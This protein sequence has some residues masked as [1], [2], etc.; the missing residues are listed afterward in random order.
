MKSQIHKR[1]ALF[2]MLISLVFVVTNVTAKKPV[3]P[4]PAD[5]P[6]LP[7][8]VAIM[9]GEENPVSRLYQP[10]V[11]GGGCLGES[12]MQ[13]G[14]YDV[15]FDQQPCATLTTDLDHSIGHIDGRGYIVLKIHRQNH[16]RIFDSAWIKGMANVDGEMLVHVSAEMI[17]PDTPPFVEDLGDGSFIVHLHADNVMLWQCN[18]QQFKRKTKCDTPAGTFAIEHLLYFPDN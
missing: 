18:S 3:K 12:W 16:T 7:Y 17:D 2:A 4:P 9:S 14:V 11:D 10:Y 1:L 6:S 8:L 15:R 13:G 5:H